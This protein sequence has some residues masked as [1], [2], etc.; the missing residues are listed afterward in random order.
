MNTNPIV[1]QYNSIQA[2]FR[3]LLRDVC[4]AFTGDE[5]RQWLYKVNATLNAGTPEGQIDNLNNVRAE[6]K[7]ALNQ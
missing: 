4:S 6:L 2:T 5:R 3:E 7:K 1:A